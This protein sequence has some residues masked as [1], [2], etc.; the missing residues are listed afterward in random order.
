MQ[1]INISCLLNLVHGSNIDGLNKVLELGH[2]L[3]EFLD[4]DL[5]VLHDAH[6][7]K[8]LDAIADR[9]QL[10]GSPEEAVHLDR[11]TGL[12]H[13]IHIGLVIPGL[14]VKENVGLGDHFGLLSFLGMVGRETL[15]GDSL[16][17][18]V[19]LLLIR[20]KEVD[21]IIII[22]SCGGGSGLG[23]LATIKTVHTSLEGEHQR[24]QVISDWKMLRLDKDQQSLDDLH[25][26]II[27]YF[28]STGCQRQCA[29]KILNISEIIS[30]PRHFSKLLVGCSEVQWLMS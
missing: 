18:L 11:G 26:S 20:S 5:I 8:L 19:I 3:A 12:L 22:G 14:H 1:C 13:F 23:R 28:Y 9:D 27:D 29:S 17:L 6:Q 10:R 21:I 7:L 15:L 4:G 2:L 25:I 30:F 16:L 24:L